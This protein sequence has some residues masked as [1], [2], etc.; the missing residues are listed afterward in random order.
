M[1]AVSSLAAFYVGDSAASHDDADLCSPLGS[2]VKHPNYSSR[3]T[4]RPCFAM[5]LQACVHDRGRNHTDNTNACASALH[6]KVGPERENTLSH[7]L[8]QLLA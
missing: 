1:E 2:S 4:R 8:A 7:L 3:I 5:A 6:T